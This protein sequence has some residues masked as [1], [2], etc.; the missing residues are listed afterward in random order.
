MKVIGDVGDVRVG[1]GAQ[2]VANEVIQLH[3]GDE[4]GGLLVAQRSAQNARQTEQGVAAAC[5]AIGL[6]V[7]ADH[8]ALDA[9]CGG[10]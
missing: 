10:L 4:M 7:S 9:E 8:L 1:H 3:V 2:Q 5:Q 6:A